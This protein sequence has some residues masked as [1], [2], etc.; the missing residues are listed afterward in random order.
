MN[1]INRKLITIME[2]IEDFLKTKKSE[3]NKDFLHRHPRKELELGLD[4]DHVIVDRSDWNIVRCNRA[5]DEVRKDRNLDRGLELWWKV[6]DVSNGTRSF[7]E[8]YHKTYTCKNG[9]VY[10]FTCK[11]FNKA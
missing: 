4:L 7:C 6:L 8:A 2:D 11:E 5:A 10:C 1:F 9:K 3:K